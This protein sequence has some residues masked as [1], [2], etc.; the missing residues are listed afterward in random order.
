RG[1]TRTSTSSSVAGQKVRTIAL[2]MSSRR[3]RTFSRSETGQASWWTAAVSSSRVDISPLPDLV[4]DRWKLEKEPQQP[5]ASGRRHLRA[6]L[7]W[8]TAYHRC[9]DRVAYIRRQAGCA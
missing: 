6:A 8:R 7:Q 4:R 1:A 3:P 2:S 5:A 9:D